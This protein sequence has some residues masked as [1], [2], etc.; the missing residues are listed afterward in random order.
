MGISALPVGL[1][2]IWQHLTLVLTSR[3]SIATWPNEHS[4]QLVHLTAW[5]IHTDFGIPPWRMY[6]RCLSSGTL[7]GFSP[8]SPRLS[9]SSRFAWLQMRKEIVHEYELHTEKE[10]DVIPMWPG[11]KPKWSSERYKCYRHTAADSP[12]WISVQKERIMGVV[13]RLY[14][15]KENIFYLLSMRLKNIHTYKK[16]K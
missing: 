5:I 15:T 3:H 13:G 8:R 7:G 12:R 1:D 2:Q 14:L 6:L 10:L 16:I 11:L 4:R 9:L